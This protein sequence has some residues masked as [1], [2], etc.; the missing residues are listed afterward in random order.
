MIPSPLPE[1]AEISLNKNASKTED[2]VI[3][4]ESVNEAQL[5]HDDRSMESH[6]SPNMTTFDS[7]QSNS[8]IMV[9]Q[10]TWKDSDDK[11]EK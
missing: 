1:T 6:L 10:K 4:E 5:D 8:N 7:H 9:L 11:T 2:Q 3:Y